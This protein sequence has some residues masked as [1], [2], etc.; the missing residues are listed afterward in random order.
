MS[1]T[2]DVK[3][4]CLSCNNVNRAELHI[5]FKLCGKFFS[6]LSTLM[7]QKELKNDKNSDIE[8]KILG[9]L[10]IYLVA[11]SLSSILFTAIQ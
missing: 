11:D 7:R 10:H 1:K 2:E 9:A 8:G 3:K 5:S 4:T 6:G